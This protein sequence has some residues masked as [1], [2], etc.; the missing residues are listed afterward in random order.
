MA[1][2]KQSARNSRAQTKTATP[3]RPTSKPSAK[4]SIAP[5]KTLA[6]PIKVVLKLLRKLIHDA[7]PQAAEV[8]GE[9]GASYDANGVFARIEASD[10]RVL[11]EFVN[12]AT[13]KAPP[14]VLSGKGSARNLAI[15]S[16][17][18]IKSSVLKGLVRQAVLKNLGTG[19]A[20]KKTK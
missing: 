19:S 8:L 3:K 1:A 7:A 2:K 17:D 14:G 15:D 10:R 11:L 13:L 6:P 18:Q 20:R 16:V 5:G 9:R 4:V 12:G